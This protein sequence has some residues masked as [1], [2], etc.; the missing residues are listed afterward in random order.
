MLPNKDLF[1]WLFSRVA[2]QSTEEEQCAEGEQPTDQ[3][4]DAATNG[5][6]RKRRMD[7]KITEILANKGAMLTSRFIGDCLYARRA[8]APSTTNRCVCFL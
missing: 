7:D 8:A 4:V 3:A 6:Y 5:Q 1:S 2:S